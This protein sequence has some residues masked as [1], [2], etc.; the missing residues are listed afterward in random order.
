MCNFSAKLSLSGC[1]SLYS[2]HSVHGITVFLII[3][4][5]LVISAYFHFCQSVWGEIIFP[6]IFN[7]I[8]LVACEI[9]H[10]FTC[11][12]HS[13]PIQMPYIV[14][15]LL[16]FSAYFPL[17]VPLHFEYL[18]FEILHIANIFSQN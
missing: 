10:H 6:V 13:L 1:I 7:C 5:T 4:P 12:F 15:Y 16:I 2:K 9:G 14:N 18:Y 8:F 11:F 17:D 3:L